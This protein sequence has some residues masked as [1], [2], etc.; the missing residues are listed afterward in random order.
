MFSDQPFW[1]SR[2]RDLGI[3]TSVP[4][5]ELTVDRLASAL[6]DA[7]DPGVAGRAGA[8]AEQ[9]AMDGAAVAARRLVDEVG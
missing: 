9:I 7:S 8:I 1:A 5:A 4:I 3:G 6:R 2:V